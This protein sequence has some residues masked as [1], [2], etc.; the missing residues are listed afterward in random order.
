MYS[1]NKSVVVPTVVLGSSLTARDMV[2]STDARGLAASSIAACEVA[3]GV[4]AAADGSTSPEIPSV[5]SAA[6]PR[7]AGEATIMSVATARAISNSTLTT[8]AS[9]QR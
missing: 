8:H 4:D 6:V 2:S 3:T 9:L 5:V 1:H 7:S